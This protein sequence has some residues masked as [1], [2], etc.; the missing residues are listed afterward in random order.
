MGTTNM[1]LW[2][3]PRNASD[4]FYVENCTSCGPHICLPGLFEREWL[5]D[6]SVLCFGS[7]LYKRE[8]R[9]KLECLL[10]C[11]CYTVVFCR[12]HTLSTHGG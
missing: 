11:I 2:D 1:E 3:I 10:E 4:Q 12:A 6:L 5:R 8:I 7:A 9:L